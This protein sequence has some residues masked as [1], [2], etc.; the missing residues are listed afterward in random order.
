MAHEEAGFGTWERCTKDVPITAKGEVLAILDVN[1][2]KHPVLLKTS[3]LPLNR[4][5]Q[6]MSQ[7]SFKQDT[8]HIVA[9]EV[10]DPTDSTATLCNKFKPESEVELRETGLLPLF[11]TVHL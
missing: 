3:V 9:P 11:L 8:P 10:T 7:A 6:P 4:P 1:D 5:I 2:P